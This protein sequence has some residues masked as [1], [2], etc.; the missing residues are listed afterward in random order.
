MY[1]IRDKFLRYYSMT[2]N[3]YEVANHFMPNPM[4]IEVD[5]TR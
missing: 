3:N 5:A 4:A 2:M 1:N